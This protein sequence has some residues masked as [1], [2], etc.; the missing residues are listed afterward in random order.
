MPVSYD[1]TN[2]YVV[3]PED[4]P[5]GHPLEDT[6]CPAPGCH[7]QACR[8]C[9][10][11]CDYEWPEGDCAREAAAESEQGRAQRINAERAAFG[12]PPIA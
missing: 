11:G 9:G 12:L 1:P 3:L 7:G 6:N 8:E 10:T 2:G 4:C 5:E